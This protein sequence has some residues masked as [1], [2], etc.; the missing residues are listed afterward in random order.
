MTG[1]IL[2][3]SEGREKIQNEL[4]N[5]KDRR[6]EVADRIRTAREYGD[7]SENSEYEDAK[8]EQSF[9]EGRILE[10][11]EMLRRA[12][13]VAKNGTDKVEM[14]STVILRMDGQTL[15]YTI[16]SSSESDPVSGK[17]SSESP[18]GFSLFG[19]TKGETVE[20]STPNGKM[21]C[22]IVSIK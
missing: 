4:T 21:T 22:K 18:I 17:I 16:V 12:R 13:V 20:I 8:N 14:G 6:R 10:L 5:L 7:L 2:L 1:D 11:E 3:T 19:K 9:V 15:E